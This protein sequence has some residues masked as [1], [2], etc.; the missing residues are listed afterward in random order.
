MS[1][2]NDCFNLKYWPASLDGPEEYGCKVMDLE[3]FEE[4]GEYFEQDCPC[5][6]SRSEA[7]DR[8]ADERRELL[9]EDGRI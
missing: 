3:D 9:M 8:A 4:G 6:S 2:C 1:D 5:H 7:E